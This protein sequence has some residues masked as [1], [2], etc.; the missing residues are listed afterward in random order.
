MAKRVQFPAVDGEYVFKS[1]TY[2]L[3][4]HQFA[5]N[6]NGSATSGTVTIEAKSPG[7]NV[8]EPI[9]DGTMELPNPQAILFVFA[10]SKFRVTLSNF[11]GDAIQL[12]LTHSYRGL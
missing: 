4:Y 9:P 6:S 8:W 10:M 11:T 12:Y 2:N 5:F 3:A 1:K 7:S